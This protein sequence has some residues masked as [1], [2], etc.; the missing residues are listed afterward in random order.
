MHWSRAH[1]SQYNNFLT[2]LKKKTSDFA[3]QGN[4]AVAENIIEL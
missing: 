4:H 1:T 2:V 3:F